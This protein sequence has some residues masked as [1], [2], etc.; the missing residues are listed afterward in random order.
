M[1]FFSETGEYESLAIGAEFIYLKSVIKL[2]RRPGNY[3]KI[4]KLS[5]LLVNWVMW[6]VM[7]SFDKWHLI[8]GG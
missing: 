8:K 4:C 1:A 2:E 3:I 5:K 6:S 7:M